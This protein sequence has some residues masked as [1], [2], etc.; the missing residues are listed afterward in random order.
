[1]FRRQTNSLANHD[2]GSVN[3]TFMTEI[4]AGGVAYD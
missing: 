2:S 3:L 1:M 4:E